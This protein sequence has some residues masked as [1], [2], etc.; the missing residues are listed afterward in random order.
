MV[1]SFPDLPSV[2]QPYAVRVPGSQEVFT[3]DGAWE[4]IAQCLADDSI[5]LFEILLDSPPDK[6]AWYMVAPGDGGTEI[7][8]KVHFGRSKIVGRSFHVSNFRRENHD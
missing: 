3:N 4:F 5:E 1:G 7:Y 2:W 8:M 6:R